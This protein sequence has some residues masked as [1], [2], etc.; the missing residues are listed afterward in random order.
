M[1]VNPAK[2][3]FHLVG[4]FAH[5]DTGDE[6]DQRHS[7]H[8]PPRLTGDPHRLSFGVGIADHLKL[9]NTV[10]DSRSECRVRESNGSN[11]QL[12]L[13]RALPPI[14]GIRENPV[15]GKDVRGELDPT[16]GIR[17]RPR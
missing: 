5:G 16:P 6:V 4:L 3:V 10:P 9:Q 1:F 17:E 14:R 13:D 2:D 12:S 15:P 7:S 11:A 8:H